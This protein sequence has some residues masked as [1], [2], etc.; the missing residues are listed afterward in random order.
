MKIYLKKIIKNLTPF[1]IVKFI[2]W[3]NFYKKYGYTFKKKRK[4]FLKLNKLNICSGAVFLDDY[5]NLDISPN[6]DLV[7][8]LE[9]NNL[10]FQGERFEVII[11][12][13]AV[14][15]FEKK[16]AIKILEETYRVLKKGGVFRISTQCLDKIIN[17]YIKRDHTF[18]NQKQKDGTVRFPGKTNAEKLLNWFYGFETIEGH[19]TKYIYNFD[20]LS[21]I[22]REIGFKNI[23]NKKFLE[24]R[25]LDIKDIDNRNDQCFIIECEK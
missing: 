2:E 3:N 8:D 20:I 14:N 1:G 22:L 17:Y 18:F 4:D 9:K 10:P 11:F 7:L 19:K 5:I 25:L 6:S 13:S 15:Y 12:M 24:S 16:R 23:K 21:N